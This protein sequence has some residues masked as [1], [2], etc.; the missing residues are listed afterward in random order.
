[1]SVGGCL[2]ELLCFPLLFNT[3]S[4]RVLCVFPQLQPQ[5]TARTVKEDFLCS[6]LDINNI[7]D[8]TS[9]AIKSSFLSVAQPKHCSSHFNTAAIISPLLSQHRFIIFSKHLIRSCEDIFSFHLIVPGRPRR[10]FSAVCLVFTSSSSPHSAPALVA[11]C[12][13]YFFVLRSFIVLC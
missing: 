6:Y 7:S 10:P 13:N 5:W 2:K 4:N 12:S 9:M 11:K 8:K 1:M 3:A